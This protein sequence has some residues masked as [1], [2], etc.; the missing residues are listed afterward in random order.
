MPRALPRGS[1]WD[2]SSVCWDSARQGR[3]N[4]VMNLGWHPEYFLSYEFGIGTGSC[5]GFVS[6]SGGIIVSWLLQLGSRRV[7]G[8]SIQGAGNVSWVPLE[9]SKKLYDCV[10]G[11]LH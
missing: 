11:D 1:L 2:L 7:L 3:V 9:G 10:D 6:L 8:G 4:A 5:K